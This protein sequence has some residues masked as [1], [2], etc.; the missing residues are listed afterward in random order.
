MAVVLTDNDIQRLVAEPKDMPSDYLKRMAGRT[1]R[2]HIEGGFDVIGEDGSE[3]RII[4]RQ[5]SANPLDFSVVLGYR[6]PQSNRLFRLRRY[7]GKHGEHTNKLENQTFYDFHMHE[8]TERYQD[9]GFEED[10]YAER[11]DRYA[12]LSSA[13]DCVIKDCGFKRPAEPQTQLF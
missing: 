1:K 13:M 6:L 8:A 10:T 11:T 2:G 9:A 3:F 7:N 4:T 12:D 5:A